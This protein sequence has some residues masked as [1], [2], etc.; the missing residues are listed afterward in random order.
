MMTLTMYMANTNV[1]M[2]GGVRAA[3]ERSSSMYMRA[4]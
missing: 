3:F 2:A 1:Q 4:A